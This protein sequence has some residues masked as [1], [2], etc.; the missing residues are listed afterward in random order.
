MPRWGANQGTI[1][2]W[3]PPGLAHATGVAVSAV[4]THR[5][6]PP[7]E[8][9]A[10]FP[11]RWLV[12]RGRCIWL[13]SLRGAWWVLSRL[14]GDCS[15]PDIGLAT[16]PLEGRISSYGLA[17]HAIVPLPGKAGHLPG[18]PSDNGQVGG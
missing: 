1:P 7:G 14:F 12:P 11:R 6:F 13:A 8:T 15:E 2:C 5:A 3:V 18:Q 16:V 4:G 9:S 10:Y 17:E